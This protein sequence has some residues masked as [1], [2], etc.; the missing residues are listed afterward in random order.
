M[1]PM[2][3]SSLHP[4]LPLHHVAD[5]VPKPSCQKSRITIIT[6]KVLVTQISKIVHFDCHTQKPICANFQAFSNIFSLL[7]D[8]FHFLLGEFSKKPKISH[9]VDFEWEKCIKM[10]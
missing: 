4:I 10:A 7:I 1:G 6:Q 8:A 5:P 2:Q 9:F 3:Q